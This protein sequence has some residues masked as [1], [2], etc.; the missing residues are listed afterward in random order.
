ML[1]ETAHLRVRRLCATRMWVK[2]I[3]WIASNVRL[4]QAWNSD[5][6]SSGQRVPPRI[7]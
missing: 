4:W 5:V 7:R 2:E 3:Q 1:F 6:F